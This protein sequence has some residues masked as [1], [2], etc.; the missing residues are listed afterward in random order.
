MRSRNKTLE[1]DFPSAADEVAEI[2]ALGL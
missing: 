2:K 1:M